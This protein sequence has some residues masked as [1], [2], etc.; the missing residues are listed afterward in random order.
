MTEER[1]GTRT[2]ITYL[3]MAI[4]QRWKRRRWYS[5]I[6]GHPIVHVVGSSAPDALA[7]QLAD[8]LMKSVPYAEVAQQT[9]EGNPEARVAAYYAK[10]RRSDISVASVY[11]AAGDEY[12]KNLAF[13]LKEELEAKG[14]PRIDPISYG[15]DVVNKGMEAC[16]N[17]DLD[18]RLINFAGR[19]D[20]FGSFLQGIDNACLGQKP[21]LLAGDD[22][23]KFVLSE[24]SEDYSEVSF[25]YFSFDNQENADVAGRAVLGYDATTVLSEAVRR[26]NEHPGIPCTPQTVWHGLAEINGEPPFVG[27]S[28]VIDFGAPGGQIAMDKAISVWRIHEG[29]LRKLNPGGPPPKPERVLLCGDLQ[30]TEGEPQCPQDPRSG[31]GRGRIVTG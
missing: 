12:S 16:T 26:I 25:D 24:Q 1:T 30:G 31:V 14:M 19:G 22:V 6:P 9:A 28:G 4:G 20:D 13:D 3:G 23:S 10:E 15:T 18:S 11:Y 5:R 21:K 2:P 17:D 27:E 29:Q 8:H 7:D